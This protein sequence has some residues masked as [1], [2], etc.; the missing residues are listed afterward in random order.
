MTIKTLAQINESSIDF[1]AEI[2]SQKY[3]EQFAAY[4]E[5]SVRARVNESISSYELVALGQQLDQYQNY[6]KF[7]EDQGNLGSL[8]AVPQIALDVITAAVGFYSSITFF[9]TANGRGT[10]NRLL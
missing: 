9:C 8:G 6:Q 3:P 1:Q 10:W 2:L 7:Q 5:G 4:Q